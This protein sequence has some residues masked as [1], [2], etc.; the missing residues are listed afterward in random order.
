MTIPKRTLAPL[1]F[2]LLAAFAWLPVQT[3]DAG[4]KNGIDKAFRG[5]IIIS[6]DAL[7]APDPSD[8]RGTIKTYKAL[9]LKVIKSAPSDGVA[10]WNFHFM[11]FVKTKPKTSNLT[12]EFYTDDK[13]KLF[14]ADK[15]LQGADPNLTILTSQVRIT[16]DENLNR[17][18][19]YI[20][21]LVA[22]HGKKSVV[23]ASTKLSTK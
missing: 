11:A 19:N 21:K 7:P 15:R 8:V 5:Q 13:E 17:G 3:A 1:A 12:L 16:E 23:L 6:D 9:R 20:V 18:R 10:S 2:L 14:V 22:M 4:K